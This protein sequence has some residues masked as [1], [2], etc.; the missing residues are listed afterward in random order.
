[1]SSGVLTLDER[2]VVQRVNPAAT[3]ILGCS[4]E[5]LIG[6]EVAEVLGATMPMLAGHLLDALADFQPV[7]RVEIN[8]ERAD[9]TVVPLGLSLSEQRGLDGETLGII[10]V[11][12]DLT[13][14]VRMRERIRANDRLAAMGEL[15]ASIA[16]EIRNPLAS[17]RGSVEML[18]SELPLDGENARLMALVLKESERLN[19]ILE[20]FLAYARLKPIAR[21]NCHLRDVIDEFV[22]LVRH[23][24]GWDEGLNVEIAPLPC[25]VVL[26]LDEELMK[27]VF[28]NLAINSAEAMHG[29]GT[30]TIAVDLVRETDQV[31]AKLRF[32]DE[33]GGVDEE[34]LGRLFEPFFTTKPHGT[35]LGLPLA[36]RI[37]TNH[38]GRLEVAN[39]EGGAEFVMSLPVVGL[40]VEGRLEVGR[41]AL[42]EIVNQTQGVTAT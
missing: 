24:A 25:D 20:D 2:G 8:V 10:A 38:E 36:S 18:S 29:E 22:D 19:R 12:Q 13:A 31:L 14:V 30:L 37:V 41:D 21:R 32:R 16:H 26:S 15:S 33:G 28:L 40:W 23:R 42:D 17:I 5:M 11:F 9:G 3:R 6:K 4:E 7:D 27:Q 35:G 1:M 39:V 34:L